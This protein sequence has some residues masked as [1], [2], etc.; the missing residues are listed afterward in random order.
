MLIKAYIDLIFKISYFNQSRLYE[1]AW[2]RPIL[3]VITVIR[4]NCEHLCT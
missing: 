4:Y 1:H 3:F 2:E